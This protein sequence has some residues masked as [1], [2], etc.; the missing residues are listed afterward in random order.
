M[1]QTTA[2]E[3]HKNLKQ[4]KTYNSKNVL[5]KKKLNQHSLKQK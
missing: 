1:V 2:A 5:K 3:K 4:L